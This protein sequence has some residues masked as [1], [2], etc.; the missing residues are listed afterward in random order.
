M[1]VC[2]HPRWSEGKCEKGCY[3][4]YYEWNTAMNGSSWED[5]HPSDNQVLI[6]L[7]VHLDKTYY[8][9]ENKPAFCQVL[10]SATSFPAITG[11][12]FI[13][14]VTRATVYSVLETPF[15]LSD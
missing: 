7:E 15:V 13:T 1:H 10:L 12:A 14:Y 4:W 9:V 6:S 8:A 11:L 3:R 2:I 5:I